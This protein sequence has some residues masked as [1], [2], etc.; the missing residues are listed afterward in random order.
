MSSWEVRVPNSRFGTTFLDIKYRDHAAPDEVMLDKKTG[1]I[2][3]RRK[4]GKYLFFDKESIHVY[5][6]FSQI[7][8]RIMS[9]EY[10]A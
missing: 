5:E 7:K 3:Y 8:K 4:D 2:I 10:W 9:Y 1:E 6:H